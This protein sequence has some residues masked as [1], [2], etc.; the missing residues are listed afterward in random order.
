MWCPGSVRAVVVPIS[1]GHTLVMNILSDSVCSRLAQVVGQ[2]AIE[3]PDSP[4]WL[5]SMDE[6]EQLAGV[7]RIEADFAG[8]ER[9]LSMTD[10][11]AL[12]A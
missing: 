10:W 4:A 2:L 9:F 1:T 12:V 5:A 6:L 7:V 11:R 3:A 8:A